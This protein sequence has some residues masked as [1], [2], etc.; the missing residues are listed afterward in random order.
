MGSRRS[1][2]R[3]EASRRGPFG[4][5]APVKNL[6]DLC[7]FTVCSYPAE[8]A[9]DIGMR[10]APALTLCGLCANPLNEADRPPNPNSHPNLAPI[11]AQSPAGLARHKD[12]KGKKT[13]TV[14]PVDTC[15]AAPLFSLFPFFPCKPARRLAPNHGAGA[16]RREQRREHAHSLPPLLWPERPFWVQAKVT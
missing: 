9:E 6:C 12:K 3:P 1:R 8:I 14:L 10:C 15:P 11:P 16:P 2:R 13:G 5:A 7:G 4:K